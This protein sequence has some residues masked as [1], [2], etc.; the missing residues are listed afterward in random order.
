MCHHRRYLGHRGL[1]AAVAVLLLGCTPVRVVSGEQCRNGIDDDFDGRTD[2]SDSDCA[3]EWSCTVESPYDPELPAWID[4]IDEV[5]PDLGPVFDDACDPA[6]TTDRRV[7]ATGCHLD[8]D[9]CGDGLRCVPL[10]TGGE[11]VDTGCVRRGCA[12][13]LDDCSRTDQA[14][15]RTLAD[16]CGV[17]AQ[18]LE[19]V[20]TCEDGACCVPLCRLGAGDCI[21]CRP[22]A[23]HFGPSAAAHEELSG[24]G[25]CAD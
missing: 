13:V 12:D 14:G 2:C 16:A 18:C 5:G 23:W 7:Y 3:R 11:V 25:V 15:Q 1:R 22:L 8:P 20:P 4:E 10:S 6:A 17:G 21:D 9:D 19:V 24:L